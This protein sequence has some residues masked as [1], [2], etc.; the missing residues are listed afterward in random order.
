MPTPFPAAPR[1]DCVCLS[2]VVV[3]Q[4]VRAHHLPRPARPVGDGVAV[5]V[6]P[7]RVGC[8]LSAAVGVVGAVLLIRVVDPGGVTARP[9]AASTVETCQVWV[10]E[11]D[12][13]FSSVCDA[14]VG[15]YAPGKA[16]RDA[17][18]IYIALYKA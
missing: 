18:S 9:A 2:A 6:E 16:A 8:V 5:G 15:Q 10:A 14:R 12:L 7:A 17:T 11:R 1:V 13:P 3:W 4:C